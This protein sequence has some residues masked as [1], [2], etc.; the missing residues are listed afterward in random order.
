MSNVVSTDKMTEIRRIAAENQRR[1]RLRKTIQ[2]TLNYGL[3]L[4][5]AFFFMFPVIIMVIS[6]FKPEEL[7]SADMTTIN[8]FIPRQTNFDNFSC[9]ADPERPEKCQLEGEGV[10]ERTPFG[11]L[12]FNSVFTT[13]SI[14]I[15]GLIV[16]SM[17]AYSLARLRWPGRGLVLTL[18]IALIIIPFE[19]VAVPLLILVNRLPWFTGTSWINTYH[20]Q[21]IPFMADAFS[22]FLFYQ[23][24]V[25]IPKDFD[26]AA[27]VDGASGFRIFWQLILPLARP[28]IATV[29]I[30]QFLAYWGSFLWPL[31]TTQGFSKTPLPVGMQIFFGQAPRQWGDILAFASMVTVPVLIVFLIFQRWFIQSVSSAGVKG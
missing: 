1:A 10:F 17:A 3:M 18:I 12:M 13:T 8:A 24:F 19:S 7:V 5:L 21:I 16:N 22:I 15:G 6:S 23:F 25:N 9:T 30:L 27:R 26:E 4:I 28:V 20:V 11:L 2:L 31:M 14:V 29:A